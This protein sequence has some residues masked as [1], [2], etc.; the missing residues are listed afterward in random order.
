MVAREKTKRMK[1]IYQDLKQGCCCA[2]LLLGLI[3]VGC[4]PSNRGKWELIHNENFPHAA[5]FDPIFFN[6][7][8]EGWVLAWA[9]LDKVR[10]KGKTWTPVLTNQN[11]DSGKAFYSF[12]F[13][14]A[15]VGFVVGTQKKGAGYTVLILQT[16][17]GGETWQ[18]R[19]AD[20]KP[21]S[22]FNKAPRLQGVTF[23]GDKSGWAVGEHLILHTIDGGQTWQTQQSNVNGNDRLFTVAC[24]SPERAWAVG[25]GGLMLRTSDAGSTWTHQE[26]GTKDTL[27]RVRFFGESG[28]IVGG[29]YGKSQVFRTTDGGETWQPQQLP[30]TKA[31]LFDIFFRGTHGWIAGEAGTLLHSADSGQTWEQEK[32]PTTENLTSLFFL[33]PNQG[34]AGGEKL[35]L[36]R[37]SN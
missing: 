36:L 5:A 9:E 19:P 10:D 22:D 16:S 23:C 14:T 11:G 35:T 2:V 27:M 7:K 17:D 4:G 34:W 30:I 15:K 31:L 13:R 37:F 12:T 24:A 18:D 28:W 20:V 1:L 26:I 33:S 29:A 21:E 25:T 8:G 32:V 3:C 6:D